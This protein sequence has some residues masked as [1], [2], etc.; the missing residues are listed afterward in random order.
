LAE[1]TPGA[2][3]NRRIEELLE[4]RQRFETEN[5]PLHA[6]I[7]KAEEAYTEI[8]HEQRDVLNDIVETPCLT[9]KA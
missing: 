2:A 8:S 9:L 4:I 5:A 3:V 7:A 1:L 6:A